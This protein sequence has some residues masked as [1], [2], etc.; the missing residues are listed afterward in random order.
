LNRIQLLLM[1]L[2]LL[3]CFAAS[4]VLICITAEMICC[5]CISFF[6]PHFFFR[7]YTFPYISIH[8]LSIVQYLRM[9]SWP[10]YIGLC[11]RLLTVYFIKRGMIMTVNDEFSRMW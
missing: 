4:V 2:L 9:K 1:L 10:W 8:F 7:A 6:P 3:Q 5:F 11:N